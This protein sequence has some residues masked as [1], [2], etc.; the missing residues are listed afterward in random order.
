MGNGRHPKNLVK[1]TSN[2]PLGD[3]SLKR[4]QSRFK[5]R[6]TPTKCSISKNGQY[7]KKRTGNGVCF[8]ERNR[9]KKEKEIRK[10]ETWTTKSKH[11]I[12]YKGLYFWLFKLIYKVINYS[13]DPGYKQ[14]SLSMSPS[15]MKL[16]YVFPYHFSS[17]REWF[18]VVLAF[19]PNIN[20]TETDIM[21]LSSNTPKSINSKRILPRPNKTNKNNRI[22]TNH[23]HNRA[24]EITCW[25]RVMN[26]FQE[27][28]HSTPVHQKK[29]LNKEIV[30][31]W[32]AAY[33]RS[34]R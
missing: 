33:K 32:G 29:I 4:P 13:S 26:S 18:C 5:I 7:I 3:K 22:K 1:E 24:Y 17:F 31:K 25:K 30:Q 21:R 16:S 2:K 8:K 9:I 11:L 10:G 6:P 12:D 27:E 34:R 28:I 14:W 19:H 20:N 23:H 15:S